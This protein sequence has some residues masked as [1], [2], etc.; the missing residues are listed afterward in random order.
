MAGSD[1]EEQNDDDIANQGFAMYEKVHRAK[2]R[3]RVHLRY[4]VVKINDKEYMF[5]KALAEL[6]F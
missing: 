5:N 6:L 4:G 3:W 2:N 1:E